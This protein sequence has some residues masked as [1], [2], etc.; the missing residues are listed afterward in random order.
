V[1]GASRAR[2]LA[3]PAG[4]AG[5]AAH[6]GPSGRPAGSGAPAPGDEFKTISQAE[7]ELIVWTLRKLSGNQTEVA[8]RLGISRSTLW[9]KIKEYNIVV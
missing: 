2:L 5:P 4:P 6:A 8:K 7:R 3:G 1:T 9:R